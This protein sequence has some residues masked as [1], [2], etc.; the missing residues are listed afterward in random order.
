MAFRAKTRVKVARDRLT[1][2]AAVAGGKEAARTT[3]RVFNRA[4]VLSPWD[5][6]YMRGR[7]SV[8]LRVGKRRAVGRV[9]VSTRY[10]LAVHDGAA[11]HVI[12]ARRKQALRFKFRGRVVIVRSVRHPGNEGRPWLAI[13]LREVALKEGYKIVS[14]PNRGGAGGSVGLGS[15]QP[16]E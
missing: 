16:G 8:D 13:A 1:R 15:F 14:R 11:P 4:R 10:A 6:G 9:I 2:V 5:T 3:R 12:R 7:H